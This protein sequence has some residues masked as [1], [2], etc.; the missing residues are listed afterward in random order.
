MNYGSMNMEEFASPQPRSSQGRGMAMR[1]Q[2]VM[3]NYNYNSYPQAPNS[4]Q[5]SPGYPNS[6]GQY[7]FNQYQAPNS[8]AYNMQSPY[9]SPQMGYGPQSPPPYGNSGMMAPQS[10]N[11]G[12]GYQNEQNV[13]LQRLMGELNNKYENDIDDQNQ[14]LLNKIKNIERENARLSMGVD[15]DDEKYNQQEIGYDDQHVV[16]DA[17]DRAIRQYEQTKAREEADE[18]GERQRD[19]ERMMRMMPRQ[20]PE[21]I[22]FAPISET[23]LFDNITSLPP[24]SKPFMGVDIYNV[25]GTTNDRPQR[26]PQTYVSTPL[27]TDT[28]LSGKVPRAGIDDVKN[29]ISK[30]LIKN[31]LMSNLLKNVRENKKNNPASN[32]VFEDIKRQNTDI[33]R[34]K[35]KDE[36]IKKEMMGKFMYFDANK[37]KG[38]NLN[39]IFNNAKRH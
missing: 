14:E 6:A 22:L 30:S 4:A 12:Q 13:D 28:A 2:Q 11:Y 17:V 32:D 24:V 7:G 3:G 23:E 1:G 39:M 9:G 35:K 36:D 37:S 27:R 8:A 31:N 29:S 26:T 38:L 16:G 10:A 21:D 33:E 5:I 18:E 34:T 19:S 15:S 25:R 20:S